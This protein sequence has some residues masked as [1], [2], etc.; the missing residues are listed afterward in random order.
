[1]LNFSEIPAHKNAF[2]FELDNVLIPQKDYDLQVYYLF[3]NFVEYLET[4]PP[5]QDALAF[6]KKR[7]EVHG[8]AQMFKELAQT[9]GIDE[10]YDENLTLLFTNAKLPLKLLLYKEVLAFLQELVVNRKQIFI[11]TSENPVQQLNKIK[12]TEW[13]GLDRYLK[14]YFSQEFGID[15][16]KEALNYLMKENQLKKEEVLMIGRKE[17]NRV[18]AVESGIDYKEIIL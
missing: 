8:N 16:T 17:S 11:L 1:M 12:Q 7:Y 2:I 9:F 6:A 3:A 5:A 18:I 15:A 10:K 14:V 13:N 4:F